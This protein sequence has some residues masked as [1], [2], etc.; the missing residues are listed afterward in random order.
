MV[1][2]ELENENGKANGDP[3]K[4]HVK[5]QSNSSE[6]QIPDTKKQSLENSAFI[7]ENADLELNSIND[8]CQT[9]V[10]LKQSFIQDFNR[11]LYDKRQEEPKVEAELVLIKEVCQSP[12]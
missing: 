11:T 3:S 5:I 4:N 8:S 12:E 2:I 6:R 1:N 9:K 7:K 10:D